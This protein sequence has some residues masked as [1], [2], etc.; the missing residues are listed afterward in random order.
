[1]DFLIELTSK[2]IG[3]AEWFMLFFVIG[4]GLFLVF[5]S[6]FKPY[7]H[8]KHAIQVTMGKFDKE[9]DSGDVS[10]YQALASAVAATVGLGNISGVAIAIHNGGPG[11]VFWM[12]L[13]AVIGM[14]IKFYSCSLAV[15][16]RSK[17][18]A[19]ELLG[20]PMYYMVNG[21][22][23]F[24][25]PMA[26]LF[27]IAGLIGVLP[28]FTT[29]QLTETLIAV[30]KPDESLFQLGEFTWRAII[31]IILVVVTSLV[32][33][34]GLK[35]IA[36]ASAS[37]VPWMVALYM[38]AAVVIFVLNYDQILPSFKLIFTEAFNFN[39]AVQGGFWGLVLLGVR[40]AI[41]SN[42][43]GVG[44]APMFHGQSRT[45][46]PTQEGLVAMLG[47][48][49]DTIIVCTITALIIIVSGVYLESENNGI[50]LTL[51]AFERS[52][53]GFGAEFLMLLVII[54]AIS[55]LFTYSY[56]GTKC[57]GFLTN[58]K[59][60]RF[61]N[62]IYIISIIFA[63]I[64]EL[65]LVINLIDLSFAVMCIPNMIAIL[66]LSPQINA[67]MKAYFSKINHG[68]A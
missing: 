22:R 55:T 9:G 62:Y 52:L 37:L 13:T 39:T 68:K 63:A 27:S 67:N 24:G 4:G 17:D 56:Y 32:I 44:N 46:E 31:G 12:W 3:V 53:F 51:L 35:N 28:I 47:P 36:K 45:S 23:T 66:Y 54:F 2:M 26:I 8:F 59:T 60:G 58:Q 10:H 57:L 18:A 1:M 14:C 7:L 40:R 30:V 34:G 41:F 5:Y 61:Y 15:M 42:E 20:G 65:D 48:F 6:K 21:I 25:K 64:S 16:F 29:N 19:G 38:L 11:V 50:Q 49:I 33:F 43:S